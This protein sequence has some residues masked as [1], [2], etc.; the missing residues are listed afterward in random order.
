[1]RRACCVHDPTPAEG[2]MRRDLSYSLRSNTHR[3]LPLNKVAARGRKR[4]RAR[5]KGAESARVCLLCPRI[6]RSA[7]TMHSITPENMGIKI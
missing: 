6:D 2:R 3:I 1:M 4:R 5:G 7:V